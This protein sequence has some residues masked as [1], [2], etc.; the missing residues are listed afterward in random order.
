[1]E[2]GTSFRVLT[3]EG[4][5]EVLGTEFNITVRD[6]YFEVQ[7]FEGKVKVTSSNTDNETI[8]TQ[9]NALRIVNNNHNPEVWNFILDAPNW[10]H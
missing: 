7:C 1:M 5:I 8:L 10:L 6:N 4:I 9:G 2:K 3:S